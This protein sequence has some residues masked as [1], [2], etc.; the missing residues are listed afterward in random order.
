MARIPGAVDPEL[1]VNALAASNGMQVAVGGANGFPAAWTSVDGGSSWRPAVGQIPAVLGRPGI[2]QLTSVTHGLAGWL[3][4]GHVTAAAAEHPV[5]IASADGQVWSAAD[6]AAAFTD[7]GLY[8]EQ[9]VAGTSGYVIVGYQVAGGRTIAAAWWSADLAGWQ[10]AADAV[11]APGGP[12]ALDG[13]G[14]S[15]QMLAVTAGPQGFVAVGS[16]RAGAAAWTSASGQAWTELKLPLPAGATRTVLNHVASRRGRLVVAVGT[17]LTAAGQQVPFAAR[18]SDGGAT[19][20]ESTLPV[21]TLPVSTLPVAAVTALTAAGKRVHRHRDVRRHAGPSGRGG[22]DLSQRFGL[23][24]G[25]AWRAG[26]DRSRHPGHHRPDHL[27]RHGDRRRLQRVPQRRATGLLAVS[28]QIGPIR[29]AQSGRP[30]S[31]NG[32]RLAEHVLAPVAQARHGRPDR[33]DQPGVHVAD[34]HPGRG[35]QVAADHAERVDQ[36]ARPTPVGARVRGSSGSGTCPTAATHTVFSIARA[37]SSVT[38]CSSLN[39]P[40][41]TPRSAP[42]TRHRHRQRPGQLAEPDVVA[43]LQPGRTPARSHS[44]DADPGATIVGLRCPKASN[45]CSFRYEATS[46]PAPS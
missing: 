27:G 4:V 14:A 19:W 13:P 11:S 23:E 41:A 9:A 35:P 18:S 15:R 1:A 28:D 40:A 10:R 46:S 2:Q 5:V 22:V 21:S 24:G 8:P 25:H 43:D 31:G 17:A 32:D 36:H 45:R 39:S 7:S 33:P 26:P 29:Q 3:A 42:A 44:T 34:G 16:A 12:G 38:Q 30:Q 37:R 20:T 6:G